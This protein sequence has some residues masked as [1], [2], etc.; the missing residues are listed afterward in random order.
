MRDRQTLLAAVGVY[1]SDDDGELDN[2]EFLRMVADRINDDLSHA[3]PPPLLP[4]FRKCSECGDFHPVDTV[5]GCWIIASRFTRAEL[6]AK[7]GF[8]GESWREIE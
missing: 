1:V 8:E 5:D 3:P 7:Y 6:E 4:V 2:R